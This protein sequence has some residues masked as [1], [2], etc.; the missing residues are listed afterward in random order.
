MANYNINAVTRR[1]VYTGSAGVGPYAFSFEV[2]TQTDV[3]VY[4]NTTL[5][6]LTTDYTVT[7]NANGTGSITIVTGT[8]VPTTPDA[9]DQIT[10]VGSR[11]I[12]RTTDF[13]TSGDFRAA[14]INE[15]LDAL[16]IFDQQLL[17]SSG[18][19]ISAPITD[20]TSV[21]MT[22]PAKDDR[23][24]KYL[25]FNATTGNPE[26]SA[27]IDDITT[28]GAITDDIATLADI[29]DG[30]DATDAI[31]T[32]AGISGNVTTVAGIS[33]NVT[34]VAGISSDVTTVAA[35][36]TD[37]GTVAGISS[38][39]TSVA[40]VSA[41]VTTVAGISS[42]VTTVAGVSSDVTT[43]ANVASDVTTVA[44]ISGDVT[45]V[46][47]QVVGYAFSTTTTMAD[48]GSGNVRFNNATVASVTAIAIDDLDGNGVDQSAYI[49]LWDDS[50]NTI[51]GTLVFRTGG[52]DVATFNITGL[53]D[54]SGWFEVAVTHVASSGTF[55]NAEDTYIGFTRAGDKGADGAGSG[56][57]S[58]PGAAVTDNA[59][60][61]WDTT[62]GQLV[63]NSTVTI[64]D[65]GAVAAGSLTLTTDLAVA[66][67]GTGASDA[68]TA[69]TNLGVAIGSDVQA[70][71]ADTAKTDTAQTFTVSQRGTIT[72][73]NDLSFDQNA[74]NNFKCTP[75]GSGTLT[76][77]NHTAG[78]SGNI[79]LINTG[80][81]AI[82]LAATTK[83]ATNLAT[84]IS[85]AGTYWV[86]YYDDGTNAYVTTSAAFA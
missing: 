66:D 14:A 48:P 45:S 49:A 61:R 23:K 33:S 30:T 57:V 72:T 6:T 74:T 27:S 44:G 36:G 50:T 55:S 69:R 62:S 59:I 82:S 19:A 52:G 16:T 76:F 64:S 32:V 9:D 28:L 58:G 21:D 31:Q 17:E 3:D 67:G 43:V 85:A 29:E 86:S 35:D 46:A 15:Q 2:L 41:N 5:L 1:V 81:H 73:D 47:A 7:I 60:V 25:A 8:N 80:G 18:R 75:T 68:A 56:D 70:Y 38:D 63:Q 11:D 42:N 65:V 20:P 26:V 22:L 54:N 77:T 83:G 13:V 12:E 37:I 40:G 10:I 24:G 84:T 4:F 51:K 71:D 79:L 78:Q 39:V 34:T 53:T